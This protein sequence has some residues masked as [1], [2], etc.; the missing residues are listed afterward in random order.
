M[1][2]EIDKTALNNAAASVVAPESNVPTENVAP[3][4]PQ[5]PAIG[6]VIAGVKKEYRAKGYKEGQDAGFSAGYDYAQ[7]QAPKAPVATAPQINTDEIATQVA[8]KVQQQ[9]YADN[10]QRMTA[11]GIRNYGDYEAK[12]G[13]LVEQSQNNPTLANLITYTLGNSNYHA[14][15]NLATDSEIRKELLVDPNKWATDLPA[16]KQDKQKEAIKPIKEVQSLPQSAGSSSTSASR[17][18]K[19]AEM[20]GLR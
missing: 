10:V 4:A 19:A 1:T 6:N 7:Q 13:K 3:L 5:Q 18:A 12:V 2:T 20:Y 9:H 14:L 8:Q 17:L 11:D 15:Y 16:T